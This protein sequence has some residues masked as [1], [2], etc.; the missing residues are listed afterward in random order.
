MK[1]FDQAATEAFRDSWSHYDPFAT[2]YIRIEDFRRFMFKLGER[3]DI[4]WPA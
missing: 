2:G 1:V 3:S 4:G